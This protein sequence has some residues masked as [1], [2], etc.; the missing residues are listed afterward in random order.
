MEKKEEEAGCSGV[1]L[2]LLLRVSLR[3]GE[4]VWGL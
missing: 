3:G 2:V 4:R 1:L